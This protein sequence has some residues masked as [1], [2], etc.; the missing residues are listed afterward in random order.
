MDFVIRSRANNATVQK[1]P[2]PL[3]D[4]ELSISAAKYKDLKELCNKN[5][6]P[7]R[8][9]EEY[10]IMRHNETIRDTLA[11]TDEDDSDKEN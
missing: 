5:V 3:Y 10:S 7:K 2:T 9:H 1:G 6:I 11:E 8:Y 4:N